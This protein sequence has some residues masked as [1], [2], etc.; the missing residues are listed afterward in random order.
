M[1]RASLLYQAAVDE[2]QVV[3]AEALSALARQP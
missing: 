3:I 1:S 2:R